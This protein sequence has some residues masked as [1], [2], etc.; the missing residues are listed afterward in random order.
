[1]FAVV[2]GQQANFFF[3]NAPSPGGQDCL[4]CDYYDH[5]R[6]CFVKAFMVSETSFPECPWRKHW[7]PD[8]SLQLDSLEAREVSSR[9][10]TSEKF[11]R[12]PKRSR[13]DYSQLCD[14]HRQ[15]AQPPPAHPGRNRGSAKP[16]HL[17]VL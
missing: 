3:A 15:S 14:H 12:L 7:F 1:D 6:G 11:D 2:F 4:G 8:M 16:L 13:E 10:S 5:C 17:R 9:A